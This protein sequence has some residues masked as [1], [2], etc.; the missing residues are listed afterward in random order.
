MLL[1][2]HQP[3]T[4][5]EKPAKK[6]LKKLQP[7][8]AAQGGIKSWFWGHEHRF[9]LFANNAG[10]EFGRLVGHGGVPVYMTHA[11][12]NQY[13]APATY[14]DR[15]FIP[16]ILGLEHW[17]YFGFA[18]LDFTGSQLDVRYFDEEGQPSYS[19]TDTIK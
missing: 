1:T 18:V 14:E 17:A 5:Y 6:M 11:D 10:V 16:K 7:V 9:M 13:P 19:G 3:F 8:L 15:R 4:V 12:N 2:H